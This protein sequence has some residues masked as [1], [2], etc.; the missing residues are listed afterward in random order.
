MPAIQLTW[1][2]IAG[3][4]YWRDG[5]IVSWSIIALQ[6]TM[7]GTCQE[8]AMDL[9][10]FGHMKAIMLLF[11][12]ASATGIKLQKVQKMVAALIWTEALLILLFNI[13]CR[14]KMKERD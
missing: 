11:S 14:M 6:Q 2:I 4:E 5:V 12:I 10:A 1:I 13:V 3:M 8:S 9:L 7:D